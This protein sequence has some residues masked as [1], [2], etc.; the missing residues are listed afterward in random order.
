[1]A[2]VLAAAGVGVALAVLTSKRSHPNTGS[3][4]NR[5]APRAASRTAGDSWPFGESKWTV[6]VGSFRIRAN[7]DAALAAL[8]QSG[9]PRADAGILRSDVHSGLRPG[10]WVVYAGFF[11]SADEARRGTDLG[12][13]VAS[14]FRDAFPRFIESATSP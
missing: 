12:I 9:V 8:L 4:L 7:A 5:S 1:M 11:A 2:G 10:Y 14:G 6:Q 13:A 3:H